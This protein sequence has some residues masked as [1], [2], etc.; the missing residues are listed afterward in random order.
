MQPTEGPPVEHVTVYGSASGSVRSASPNVQTTL[1]NPM[2]TVQ[3]TQATAFVQPTQQQ[4]V[5]H[6]EPANQEPPSAVVEA[7]TNSQVEWP[8]TSSVFGTGEF[9]CIC[10]KR[11][12]IFFQFSPFDSVHVVLEELIL[13]RA[14][15]IQNI[16]C[17]LK[18]RQ[19]QEHLPCPRDLGTRRMLL[20]SLTRRPTRRIPPGLLCLR[21]CASFRE[22]V[23]RWGKSL[24]NIKRLLEKNKTPTP[25]LS[26]NCYFTQE[27]VLA[28][29]SAEAEGVV[30]T[31]DSAEASQV[32]HY[33]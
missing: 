33:V 2:L 6:A 26:C 3:Q 29:D 19:L 12:T 18:S 32:G 5:S 28:E 25:F 1:A 16:P 14:F 17:H 21:K 15:T 22:W 4:S 9:T 23:Q 8:S 24:Y 20:W 7:T 30:P 13:P 10:F 27:E 11:V 31:D